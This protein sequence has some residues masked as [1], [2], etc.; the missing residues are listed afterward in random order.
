MNLKPKSEE[1]LNAWLAH[2]TWHTGHDFDMNRW[3]DFV[4][5]YQKDHGFAIDE[6]ELKDWII[7]E[8]E[9]EGNE[10]LITEVS[11][12]ISLAYNILDF[13]KHTGR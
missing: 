1:K 11:R 7:Q 6:T 10:Y 3:Y 9:I 12:L 4:N 5:Q 2:E 8:A 13:L